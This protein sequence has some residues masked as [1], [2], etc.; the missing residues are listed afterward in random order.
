M[1]LEKKRESELAERKGLAVRTV[2]QFIWL[3]L[4]GVI[5]YFA[6]NWFFTREQLTYEFFY[7]TLGIPRS[8]PEAVIMGV[9]ILVIVFVM[10]FFL[11]MGY[12][13]A[14]PQGRERPGDPTPYSSTYDPMQDDYR[15]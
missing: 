4:S 3:I 14:S 6:L 9:L 7:T 10:Q 8:V 1:R 15:H 2:I 11:V 5:A 12:A 13:I